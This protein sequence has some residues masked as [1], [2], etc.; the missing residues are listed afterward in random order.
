MTMVRYDLDNLPEVTQEERTKVAAMS[1]EDIDY[2]D[3]PE[4]NDFSGFVL[5]EKLKPAKK[6]NRMEIDLDSDVAAWIGKDYQSR[7]NT[8]LREVMKLSRIASVR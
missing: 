2:S 5:A 3:I 8:I 6:R 1:D 7:I 4:V